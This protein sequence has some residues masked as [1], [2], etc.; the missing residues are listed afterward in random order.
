MLQITKEILMLTYINLL[1]KIN[2]HDSDL[3]WPTSIKDIIEW[4]PFLPIME[5]TI[6]IIETNKGR[7]ASLLKSFAMFEFRLIGDIEKLDVIAI[8]CIHFKKETGLYL[9]NSTFEEMITKFVLN[10]IFHHVGL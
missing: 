5:H 2:R 1:K 10:A 3:Y 9:Q 4:F 6:N 7:N 8:K